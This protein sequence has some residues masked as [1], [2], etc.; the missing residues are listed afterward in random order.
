MKKIKNLF[1]GIMI[2]IVSCMSL[3]N[4]LT[5]NVIEPISAL[6]TAIVYSN[7]TMYIILGCIWNLFIVAP[8]MVV[9]LIFLLLFGFLTIYDE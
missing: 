2:I 8:I 3:Y 9:T 4:V 6:I 7:L 1:L 5:T